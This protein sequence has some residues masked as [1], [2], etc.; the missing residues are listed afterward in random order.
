MLERLNLT[1]D[2]QR[3]HPGFITVIDASALNRKGVFHAKP[4]YNVAKKK[5]RPFTD[6]AFRYG[7]THEF[8]VWAS[9][10]LLGGNW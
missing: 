6:G 1:Q 3:V 8:L 4:L 9:V 7:A 10:C 2:G 5:W